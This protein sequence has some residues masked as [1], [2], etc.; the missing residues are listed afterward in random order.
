MII[1]GDVCCFTG[2]RS[3]PDNEQLTLKELLLLEI[4]RQYKNNKINQFISGG[5]RGFDLLAGYVVLEAKK[6]YSDIRLH[7][8]LPCYNQNERWLIYDKVSYER[9]LNLSDSVTYITN[10]NYFKGCM[11]KRNIA[12]IDNSKSCIAYYK[13]NFGGTMHTINY[14][15]SKNIP[16]TNIVDSL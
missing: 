14:A 1:K 8:F 16:I 9:L 6:Y 13:N 2:H 10:S 5:A 4:L 12:M 11:E 15:I 3:I 7:M